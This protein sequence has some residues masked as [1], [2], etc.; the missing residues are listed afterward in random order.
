MAHV[1]RLLWCETM[2]E[3]FIKLVDQLEKEHRL[4]VKEYL[5]LLEEQSEPNARF[6]AQ[7]VIFS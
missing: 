4:S 7:R 3:Q 5:F 2:K 6:L 1:P